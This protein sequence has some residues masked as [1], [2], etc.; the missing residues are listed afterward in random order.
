MELVLGT[1]GSGSA[2]LA[3]VEADGTVD[4]GES[5]AF[6][7]CEASGESV[8]WEASGW[9]EASAWD[10]PEAS[11]FSAVWE[12]SGGVP[13]DDPPDPEPGEPEAAGA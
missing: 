9:E 6:A 12:T 7:G 11:G 13:A 4:C 2:G 3:G 5:G 10:W 1:D 8:G